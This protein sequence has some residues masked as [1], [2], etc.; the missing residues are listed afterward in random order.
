MRKAYVKPITSLCHIG[1]QPLLVA[2]AP[3]KPYKTYHCP[4]DK[5]LVCKKYSDHMNEWARA[6]EYYASNHINY[7]IFTGEGCPY[8]KGCV[9]YKQFLRK[10][11]SSKGK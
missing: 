7:D 2:S 11:N 4:Y 9:I 3:R 10:Q 1:V 6:I 8:E 5:N